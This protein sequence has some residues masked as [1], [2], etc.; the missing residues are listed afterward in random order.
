MRNV[1]INLK[2]TFSENGT[3]GFTLKDTTGIG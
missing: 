2:A 1:N 3:T